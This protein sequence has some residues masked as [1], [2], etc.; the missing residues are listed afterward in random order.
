MLL[1]QAGALE[2]RQNLLAEERKLVDIIDQRDGDPGQTRLA[3]IDELA[4]DVVWIADDGQATHAL[5]VTCAHLLKLLRRRVLR[6]DVLEREDRVDRRPVCV[7]HDGIVVIVLGLL[8]GRLAGDDADGIDAELPALLFCLALRGR[9]PLRGLIERGA[10][11][12]QV[13]PPR[14]QAP[15]SLACSF[16]WP[17]AV[18]S[19]CAVSPSEVRD[20]CR[21]NASQL[22]L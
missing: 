21:K 11:C 1:A 3:E 12:L 17:F 22:R 16:A 19:L 5:S 20:A 15:S 2:P 8:L 10:G 18:A 4:G 9:N 6:R 14:V 7:L 13:K